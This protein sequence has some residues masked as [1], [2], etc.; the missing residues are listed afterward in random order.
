MDSAKLNDWLQVIGLF[1]VIASLIFVGLQM[2][3]D[4]E[5]ALSVAEQ[6]RTELTIEL[7]TDWAAN[8]YYQ[9]AR[10]KAD[11]GQAALMTSVERRMIRSFIF[12]SLFVFENIHYQYMQGFVSP[13]R[14]RGTRENIK[15]RFADVD[16]FGSISFRSVYE[17]S[18]PNW[19]ESFLRE[20]DLVIAEIDAEA[21]E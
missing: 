10:E 9:S 8:P 5:I 2:K 19:R 4:R 20:V 13:E 17:F 7:V 15:V 6:S 12:T 1:G 18:R 21:D 16:N 11:A 3:Q 14:W